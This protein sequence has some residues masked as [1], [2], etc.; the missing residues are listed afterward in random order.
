MRVLRL[1]GLVSIDKA[2]RLT[3]PPDAGV[4]TV[5]IPDQAFERE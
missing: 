3:I 4:A 1:S 2:P 5:E